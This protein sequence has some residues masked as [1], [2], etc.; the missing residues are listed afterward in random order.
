MIKLE[1]VTKRLRGQLILDNVDIEIPEQ[2]RV[3]VLGRSGVGKTVLLKIMAGL[4]VPD[5]GQVSYS[6]RILDYGLFAD[7][8]EILR[9]IGFVFQGGA[10]FDS[11]TV[12]DNVALP[13]R[14]RSNLT[15]QE[16]E[17]RV[18]RVLAQVGMEKAATLR[19]QELS[20]GMTRLVAIARA[21]VVEPSYLFFDE[22]T[23]GLD[24][25]SRDRICRLIFEVCYG[26]K[27]T[28]VIVTHDLDIARELGER[29]Y[30][31]RENRLFP[32]QD[33]RKEDYEPSVA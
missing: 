16:V 10:L 25:A 21:L 5:S 23:S 11:L 26:Q 20:G 12:A 6:G 7:N 31:L 2:T 1:K 3:V 27:R 13:L 17:A 22:P 32:A 8:G 15:V 19:V 24:P 28:A 14:E 29:L 18:N 9:K 30:L 4:I 33:I